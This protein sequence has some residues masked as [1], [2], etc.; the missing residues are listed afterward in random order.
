[1]PSGAGKDRIEEKPA[2][3]RAKMS[4][5]VEVREK[6]KSL[7]ERI[8]EHPELW[9]RIE[10]MLDLVENAG[11]DVVKAAEAERQVGEELQQLGQEVLQAWAERQ[12]QRQMEYWDGRRGVNRK[13]KKALLI[14]VLRTSRS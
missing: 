13:E 8:Q 5:K 14:H 4:I 12:Q 6:R 1:V 10:R 9:E 2:N 3:R 7:S 11:G